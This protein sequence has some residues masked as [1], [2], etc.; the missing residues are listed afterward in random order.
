MECCHCATFI[1]FWWNLSNSV[2]VKVKV[3]NDITLGPAVGLV[4]RTGHSVSWNWICYSLGFVRVKKGKSLVM[5]F[6]KFN[7]WI[8]LRK[9][10]NI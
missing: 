7:Q 10:V 3:N 5:D 6:K 8:L 9:R 4:I 1:V 2:K